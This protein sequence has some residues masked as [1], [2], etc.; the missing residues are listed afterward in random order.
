MDESAAAAAVTI[1]EPTLIGMV[2]SL[3]VR[4]RS[5]GSGGPQIGSL[6]RASGD[7]WRT[8]RKW[9][10]VMTKHPSSQLPHATLPL[11]V[12]V[13]SPYCPYSP[14]LSR[15]SLGP[16]GPCRSSVS[17]SSRPGRTRCEKE[18][19]CLTSLRSMGTLIN[20]K[21]LPSTG[22]FDHESPDNHRSLTYIFEHSNIRNVNTLQKSYPLQSSFYNNPTFINL[23]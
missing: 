23:S 11:A 10:N 18:K 22:A 12:S 7:Q 17:C 1:A 6:R 9:C 4:K 16:P 20:F 21:L 3:K 13:A 15:L 8:R 19:V 14:V 5:S 2:L